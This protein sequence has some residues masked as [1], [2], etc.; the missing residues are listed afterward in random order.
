[1]FAKV[2][3]QIF[4]SSIAEDY[5]CRR[6]FMDLLVL[7]DPTGAVDMTLEAI[8]RRTNVPIEEVRKYISE[9]SSPDPA[10]RSQVEQGK[11][12]TPLDSNRDWGWQIVN[13]QHYR[14][15]KD[16]EALR[17]YF[18]DAQRKHRAKQKSVKDNSLT[19]INGNGQSL[20][21]S[22]PSSSKFSCTSEEAE[23][24]CESLGLPCSDGSAMVLHWQEKKWPRNWQL[25]I[26]KWK[27][28][29]Y[30]PS[31]KQS[32][33]GNARPATMTELDKRLERDPLWKEQQEKRKAH[34]GNGSQKV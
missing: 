17:S 23:K 22:S 29:G 10:S 27:S 20:T 24:F 3:G 14:K 2:F 9:L 16:Q 1:V 18:R 34:D 15:L 31:Q 4:D 21:P 7:A 30:L 5:N 8:A 33:N 6:M 11:R 28:F 32:K 12:L 19:K 25:T 13:Y 26:R